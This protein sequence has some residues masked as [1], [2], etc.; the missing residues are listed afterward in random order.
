V[1]PPLFWKGYK[2]YILIPQK[3]LSNPILLIG[4]YQEGN[5]FK[6]NR[7]RKSIEATSFNRAVIL[8]PE[9]TR[10]LLYTILQNTIIKK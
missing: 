10:K 6:S 3:R 4:A 8:I 9:K 7:N 2:I 1:Y 5:Y